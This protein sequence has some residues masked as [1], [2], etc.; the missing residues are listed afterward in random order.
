MRSN[1]NKPAQH[2]DC[3]RGAKAAVGVEEAGVASSDDMSL[4]RAYTSV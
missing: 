1:V 3:G 2:G 4:C